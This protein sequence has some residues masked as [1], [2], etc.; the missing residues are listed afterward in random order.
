[1]VLFTGDKPLSGQIFNERDERDRKCEIVTRLDRGNS[2]SVHVPYQSIYGHQ[3]AATPS[4]WYRKRQ[5]FHGGRRTNACC[6]IIGGRVASTPDAFAVGVDQQVRL[7]RRGRSDELAPLPTD[8]HED[9]RDDYM[10]PWDNLHLPCSTFY[11]IP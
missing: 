8:T 3:L 10:D 2:P 11:N 7:E 6:V 5:R 9:K 1:M 4:L